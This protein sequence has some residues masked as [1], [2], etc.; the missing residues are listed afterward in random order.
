MQREE[1]FELH[2]E[3]YGHSPEF[4]TA[5]AAALAAIDQAYADG[6][7]VSDNQRTVLQAHLYAFFGP[8]YQQE[9]LRKMEENME[10]F[11]EEEHEPPDFD[12]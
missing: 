4:C 5:W 7:L 10:R 1:E 8:A 11:E 12:R 2:K 3:A 6:H 9:E